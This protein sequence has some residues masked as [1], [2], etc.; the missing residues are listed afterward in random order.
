MHAKVIFFK[1]NNYISLTTNFFVI[2]S[3][4]FSNNEGAFEKIVTKTQHNIRRR[5]TLIVTKIGK[6]RSKT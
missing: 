1:E 3:E 4:T 5:H 2:Q 6:H